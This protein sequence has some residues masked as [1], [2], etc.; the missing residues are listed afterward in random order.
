M[1]NLVLTVLL[2]IPRVF[3]CDQLLTF[4]LRFIFR[5][6]LIPSL[7]PFFLQIFTFVISFAIY[8]HFTTIATPKRDAKGAVVSGGEDLS[9]GGLIE[10]GWDT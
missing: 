4:I 6:P 2:A 9:G 3:L 5:R 1:E 10:W 8:N 7:G